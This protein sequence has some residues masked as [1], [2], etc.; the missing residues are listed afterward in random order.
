MFYPGKRAGIDAR[1]GFH[2]S[3]TEGAIPS[4]IVANKGHG[5]KLLEVDV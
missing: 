1:V 5:N 3:S 4:L 2:F